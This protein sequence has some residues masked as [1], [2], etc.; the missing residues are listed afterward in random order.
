MENSSLSDC[1]N[2]DNFHFYS[3]F[4]NSKTNINKFAKCSR[5]HCTL[6]ITSSLTNRTPDKLPQQFSGV[7]SGGSNGK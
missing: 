7:Q 1:K 3:A 4:Q 6:F 2:C 5:T